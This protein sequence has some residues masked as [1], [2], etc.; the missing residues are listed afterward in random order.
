[1]AKQEPT[2]S[3]VPRSPQAIKAN[4]EDRANTLTVS[5]T[6]DIPANFVFHFGNSF[7]KG[8]ELHINMCEYENADIML[9]GMDVGEQPSLGEKPFKSLIL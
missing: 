3:P 6:I 7:E 2:K 5:K 9:T 8:N 1:M 4:A